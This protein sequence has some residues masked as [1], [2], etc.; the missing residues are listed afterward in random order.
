MELVYRT[1]HLHFLFQQWSFVKNA[2]KFFEYNV[3]LRANPESFNREALALQR[4]SYDTWAPTMRR[5]PVSVR[6][7]GR[8]PV[9]AK[10]RGCVK[11]SLN[12]EFF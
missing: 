2:L 4:K 8:V 6:I 12:F 1:T 7:R 5:Y 10:I 3:L 11:L 9:S